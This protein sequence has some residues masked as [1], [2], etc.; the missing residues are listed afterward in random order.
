M[1]RRGMTRWTTTQAFAWEYARLAWRSIAIALGFGCLFAVG[2]RS[3]L[4]PLGPAREGVAFVGTLFTLGIVNI[5]ILLTYRGDS[6]LRFEP[7]LFRLPVSTLHLVL[8]RLLPALLTIAI[9]QVGV[10]SF[11]RVT[12]GANWPWLGPMLLMVAGMTWAQALAWSLGRVPWLMGVV[13]AVGVAASLSWLRP[14]IGDDRLWST[15]GAGDVLTLV[16]AT[17]VAGVVAWLG[18]VSERSSRGPTLRMNVVQ[19]VMRRRAQ[20]QLAWSGPFRAQLWMEWREKGRMMP[21][22]AV[23][24]LAVS[25]GAAAFSRQGTAELL[26]SLFLQIGMLTLVIPFIAGF[27]HGRFNLSS[28]HTEVDMVRSTRPMSDRRLAWTLLAA[29]GRSWTVTWLTMVA[30]GALVVGGAFAL[31]D[32]VVVRTML[33]QAG[34]AVA[35]LGAFDLVLISVVAMALGWILMGTVASVTLTGRNALFGY[36]I[37]APT[38][39]VLL[40]SAINHLFSLSLWT[41]ILPGAVTFMVGALPV[42]AVAVTLSSWRHGHLGGRLILRFCLVWLS[43]SVLLSIRLPMLNDVVFGGLGWDLD[44]TLPLLI[45]ALATWIVVPVAAAPLALAWNR[46][47]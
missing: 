36:L 33:D 24:S 18:V 28:R 35:N 42:L 20:S 9:M 19:G 41:R 44:R 1:T 39:L 12:Q 31:G 3:M 43:L 13:A 7:R 23:A 15:L 22:L 32:R 47:R 26:R 6:R 34:Q 30:G 25:V 38:V 14:R 10:W 37:L 4:G 29:A 2:Y 21:V 8:A 45:P 16:L 46:H 40:L 5:L 17:V 27:V 11:V